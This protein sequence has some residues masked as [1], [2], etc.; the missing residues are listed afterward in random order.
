MGKVS[1]RYA[2]GADSNLQREAHHSPVWLQW[3]AMGA[4]RFALPILLIVGLQVV[5]YI[6]V[7]VMLFKMCRKVKHLPG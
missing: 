6:G 3:P 7:A 4:I 2:R 5:W 1:G